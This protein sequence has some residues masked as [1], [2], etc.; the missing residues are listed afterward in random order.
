MHQVILTKVY[1]GGTILARK[2]EHAS[3]IL[4]LQA[5]PWWVLKFWGEI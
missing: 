4:G 2:V 3:G 1:H 5:P